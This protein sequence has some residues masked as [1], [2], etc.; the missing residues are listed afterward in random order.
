MT[1]G[2]KNTGD[3]SGCSEDI[4]Y[5]GN[6][7]SRALRSLPLSV[8]VSGYYGWQG[9]GLFN[10]GMYGHFWTSTP[11]SYTNSQYLYFYSTLVG[12]K[13]NTYKPYGLTLRCVAFQ[14]SPQPSS[15]G[16]DVGLLRLA[17]RQFRLGRH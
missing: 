9:G 13:N 12:P 17:Q 15:F 1:T 14:S 6:F 4:A 8:M 2:R 3:I 16:Y 5:L 7:P 11:N 10:R